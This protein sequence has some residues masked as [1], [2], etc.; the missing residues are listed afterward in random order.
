VIDTATD[1]LFTTVGGVPNPLGVA[2]T[3]DGSLAYVA[4]STS[5]SVSVIDTTTHTVGPTVGVGAAPSGVA[6]T[7]D[8]SYAYVSNVGDGTV[9]VIATATNTVD[10]TVMVG[11]AP[12]GVAITPAPIPPTPSA[13]TLTGHQEK[14][15]FGVAYELFNRLKWTNSSLTSVQGYYVYRNGVKIATLSATTFDYEDHD[16]KKGVTTSYSVIAFDANG[17]QSTSQTITIN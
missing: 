2:I 3:P 7:P 11:T 12:Q 15:D 17:N 1:S 13:L 16:I 9:S 6:I 5:S 14:N 10:A 4:N 8:G